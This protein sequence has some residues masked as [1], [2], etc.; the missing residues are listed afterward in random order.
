MSKKIVW[1]RSC[2]VNTICALSFFNFTG[3]PLVLYC[4]GELVP[5][6]PVYG[7]PIRERMG[8]LPKYIKYLERYFCIFW[9][10]HWQLQGEVGRSLKEQKC[11]ARGKLTFY[12]NEYTWFVGFPFFGPLRAGRRKSEFG[13]FL[14]HLLPRVRSEQQ[15]NS[16]MVTSV[17]GIQSSQQNGFPPFCNFSLVPGTVF[18]W[19]LECPRC[20]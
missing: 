13:L 4:L 15:T 1:T 16:K 17:W 5:Y 8:V 20:R 9:L 2:A 14:I 10:L 3:A 18:R 19:S 11:T 12:G 7:S 6:S